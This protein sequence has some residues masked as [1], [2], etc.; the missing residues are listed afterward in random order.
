M[1]RRVLAA[2][3][4]VCVSRERAGVPRPWRRLNPV[5]VAAA[6]K[7]SVASP[8]SGA[9]AFVGRPVNQNPHSSS[10]S[11]ERK[12]LNDRLA[13]LEDALFVYDKSAIRAD[14]AAALKDDVGVFRGILITYRSETLRSEGLC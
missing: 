3:S 1:K 6:S 5:Q 14:A 8:S 4:L 7:T 10:S 9:A 13:H 11:A 2:V 12:I